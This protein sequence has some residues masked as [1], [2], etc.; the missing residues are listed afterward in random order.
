MTLHTVK[1][2]SQDWDVHSYPQVKAMPTL[3]LKCKVTEYK[4]TRG[5]AESK[6]KDH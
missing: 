4:S 3:S 1:A 6:A 5:I 2:D